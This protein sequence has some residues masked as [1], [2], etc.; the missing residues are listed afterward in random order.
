MYT[1]TMFANCP[2]VAEARTKGKVSGEVYTGY[3]HA[4]GNWCIVAT[5]GLLCVLAQLAA[6][7]SDFF[8]SRWVNMEEK[9]VTIVLNVTPS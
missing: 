5:V 2:Q 3:F 4:G 6:S 1:R 8:I 9:Y 7:G